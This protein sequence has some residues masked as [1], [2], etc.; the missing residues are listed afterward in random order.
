MSKSLAWLA[1]VICALCFL[2]ILSPALA[3][4]FGQW[5]HQDP[6]RSAWFKRQ[7]QPDNP[8]VPCCGVAD[9]Y[10]AD[11][12]VMDGDQYFAVITDTRDDA[13]LMRPHIPPGTRIY[14][15]PHKMKR[16]N[17]DPNPTGHGIVFI[18]A[19]GIVFCYYPPSLM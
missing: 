6:D 1:A 14:I 17:H 3:R 11:E 16:N 15:P 19:S 10:E 13:P 12:F 5:Q 8:G 18:G 4:D 2:F 9:A 7:M